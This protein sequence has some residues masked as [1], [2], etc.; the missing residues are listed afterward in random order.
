MRSRMFNPVSSR[1]KRGTCCSCESTSCMK[2]ISRRCVP[3]DETTGISTP[4]LT[5]RGRDRLQR[6]R[7][8]RMCGDVDGPVT[9]SGARAI[10]AE[11]V[12]AGHHGYGRRGS[13]AITGARRPASID[14]IE[15]IVIVRRLARHA[16]SIARCQSQWP[17]LTRTRR[18]SFSDMPTSQSQ[19]ISAASSGGAPAR[20]NVRTFSYACAKRRTRTSEM[21]SRP[22]V[23]GRNAI[24]PA[25]T[26][27]HRRRARSSGGNWRG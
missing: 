10:L 8:S 20:Q 13:H 18:L 25:A 23:T 12:A 17:H 6:C 16:A 11:E 19:E 22:R 4:A 26:A 15:R 27:G 1:T 3:R 14:S 5:Q 7:E 9:N 2:Q 21:P 24:V